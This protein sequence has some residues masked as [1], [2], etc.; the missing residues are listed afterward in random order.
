[1]THSPAPSRGRVRLLATAVAFLLLATGSPAAAGAATPLR[2]S[3][4]FSRTVAAGWGDAWAASSPRSTSVRNGSAVV[5][6]SPGKATVQ[7]IREVSVKDAVLS[8]TIW[9]EKATTKGNGSTT[10]LTLRSDG[11]YSYQA[12]VRF[13]ATGVT[14][15]VSRYDGGTGKEV[16]LRTMKTV[17]NLPAKTRIRADF[18][19]SGSSPV[20]LRARM[21][22]AGAKKPDWQITVDDTDRKRIT[23]AGRAAIASYLSASSP[24][25]TVRVDDVAL[26]DAMPPQ[27]PAK[28]TTP[29]KPTKPTAPAAPPQPTAPSTGSSVG[30]APVGT[31]R[32]A[33][34]AGAVFVEPKGT[35]TGSGTKSD[36]YGSA[37]YAVLKAPSGSTLVLRG[38]TYRE[39]VSVGF[40]KAL[41]IQAYPGEAVWFDGSSPV[42]GW[43]RSGNTWVKS[44]WTHTFDHRV[45]FVAGR[46]DTRRFVDAANPLAG[47]PDQVWVDDMPL[48]QV[49]SAS[50]VTAGTFFVDERGK[51][52][53]IG[54]N[55]AGKDVEA[56]TIARAFKLQGKHTTLRGFGIQRYA[57]TVSMMGTV[58]A[59]VNDITLENMVI[60]D[61]A[62]IG[63]YG[64]NDDK[65]FR[66][67][68]LT[69]NGLMGLGVNGAARVT[70]AESIIA[71]NNSQQFAPAPASG[72]MK[73]TNADGA[74][75]ERNVVAD[76]QSA[77]V[78]FDVNSRDIRVTGNRV[79]GNATT[80]IQIELSEKAIIADNHLSGNHTGVNIIN[81]GD[82]EIWNNTIVSSWRA[83]GFSQDARRQAAPDLASTVPWVLD[84]V[85]FRNNVVS[86]ATDSSGCPILAQ[87]EE[88]KLR[89]AAVGVSMDNNVY[90]RPASGGPANFACWANGSAG[91]EG[92]ADL[93]EFRA[94][95][96]NDARSALW[97]GSPIVSPSLTV[98]S[99]VL[100]A[101]RATLAALPAGVARA[102]GVGAGTKHPGALSAPLK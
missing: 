47:Y 24:A 85:T 18:A 36:P 45:S 63:V 74:R 41:T 4:S 49:G 90:H 51:R 3:D 64:W 82:V 97:V 92:L 34:P 69:G 68:T 55:P 73:I 84:D 21:W 52:L 83:A 101:P 86:I 99:E 7:T 32:Y 94:F 40:R 88:R 22:V 102:V 28:P 31:A 61:N 17:K 95:T 93:A 59:E 8:A 16:V 30:S 1:M 89:G 91:T 70:V 57:T 48:R 15:W 96:G 100:S 12:R 43:E 65:N 10:S 75:I 25:T 44:G 19:V 98:R 81:S 72:G 87:D 78:W 6:H 14:L 76:N 9:P 77:G 54:S 80:G 53:V 50:A 37:A 2:V 46:D 67:V 60:R 23:R 62:T 11:R 66:R 27:A 20:N 13:G 26:T 58:T 38:G 56:S 35:Q 79:T 5:A 33:V 39:Y 42:T 29:T 71:D